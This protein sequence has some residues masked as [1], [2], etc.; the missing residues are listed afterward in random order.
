[1]RLCLQLTTPR[2][3]RFAKHLQTLRSVGERELLKRIDESLIG[4]AGWM[5]A[6]AD[7]SGAS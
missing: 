2:G 7:H 4:H 5:A 3:P 6:G 1:M